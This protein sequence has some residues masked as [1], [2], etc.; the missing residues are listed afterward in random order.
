MNKGFCSAEFGSWANVVNL[1]L[2]YDFA[3]KSLYLE[4][5]KLF[6]GVDNVLNSRYAYAL[7]INTS[8]N[9]GYYYMPGTTFRLGINL[10]F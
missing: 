9:K 3:F 2:D 5:A 8:G 7:E 1:R 4:R 6:L 10:N